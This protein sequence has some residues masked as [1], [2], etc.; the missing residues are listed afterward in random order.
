MS[1]S[2]KPNAGDGSIKTLAEARSTV[3]EIAPRPKLRERERDD[4]IVGPPFG[5]GNHSCRRW[6]ANDNCLFVVTD[7]VHGIASPAQTGANGAVCLDR[8]S[9]PRAHA[10]IVE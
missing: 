9:I 4:T 7:G 1:L 10:T 3:N 8:P 2:S 6:H 5:V